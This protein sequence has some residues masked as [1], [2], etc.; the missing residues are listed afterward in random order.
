[1]EKVLSSK[2]TMLVIF[3]VFLVAVVVFNFYDLTK[4][5]SSLREYSHT[6]IESM[7]IEYVNINEADFEQLCELPFISESQARSIIEYREENGAFEQVE[8]ILQVKGIGEKTY[9]K[10][11]L[12]IT[13]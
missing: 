7:K 11:K 12:N 10:I 2:K 4:D 13:I 9:E 5:Y 1:M 6:E 8:D 3:L